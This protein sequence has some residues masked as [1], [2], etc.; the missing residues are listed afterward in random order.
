M[1]ISTM[2]IEKPTKE[3]ASENAAVVPVDLSSLNLDQAVVEIRHPPA[4]LLSDR[5]GTMWSAVRE[6][7]PKIKNT[8]AVPTK[9]VFQ[10]GKTA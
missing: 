8:H 3:A 9:T 7:F 5:A 1:K 2:K 6:K 10:L 4:L